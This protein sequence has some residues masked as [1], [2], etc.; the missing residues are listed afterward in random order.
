MSRVGA[1]RERFAITPE[2]Y[3]HVAYVTLAALI[4]IVFTGAAVRLTSSGLGC[5]NWPRCGGNAL[6]PLSSHALIEFG[7]RVLSGAVGVITVAA[8]VLALLR[9]PYR[10]DLAI[11]AWLL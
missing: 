5:P 11:L 3:K 2:L 8:A 9:R 4:L 7:N 6:P 1:L 10:R